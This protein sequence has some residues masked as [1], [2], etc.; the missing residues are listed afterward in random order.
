MDAFVNAIP[1]S[2]LTPFS[3]SVPLFHS[4]GRAIA[5]Q[6]IIAVNIHKGSGLARSVRRLFNLP[7]FQA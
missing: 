3:P 6:R 1:L 7:L 2:W 4:M 5:N